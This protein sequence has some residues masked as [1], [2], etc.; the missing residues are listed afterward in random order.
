MVYQSAVTVF[1]SSSGTAATKPLDLKKIAH[2]CL[3]TDLSLR[4]FVGGGAPS[5][6]HSLDCRFVSGS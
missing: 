2:I 6:T 1:L 4:T 5:S 3:P